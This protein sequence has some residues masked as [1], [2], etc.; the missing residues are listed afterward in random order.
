MN[1]AYM[2]WAI[3]P[4][5]AKNLPPF[6]VGYCKIIDDIELFRTVVFCFEESEAEFIL[7]V[8]KSQATPDNWERWEREW[9][10]RQNE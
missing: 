6:A 3:A 5:S 1:K 10:K 9:D 4:V 8:L 7:D 2:E